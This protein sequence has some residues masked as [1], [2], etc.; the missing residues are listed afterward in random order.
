MDGSRV[1]WRAALA[2]TFRQAGGRSVLASRRHEGPL[3]VQKPLYPEG[4]DVCHAVLI[5]APGGIAG[6]DTL[7]LALSVEDGAHAL[8]TTPAAGKWYKAAGATAYQTGNITIQGRAV[9]EWLPQE[10]ILFDHARASI[11]TDVALEAASVFAGWE[12]VCLGRRASGEDF[13]NGALRQ[14]LRLSR[15]GR[16]IWGEHLNLRGGDVVMHSPAGLGGHHVYGS[17]VVAA[18]SVPRGMVD[19]CRQTAPRSGTCGV[20]VQIGPFMRMPAPDNPAV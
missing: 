2:L 5:H 3:M 8:V 4:G 15:D 18:G 11:E 19:A 1:P 7:A 9:L 17:M 14:Q 13:A 16:A 20:G 6:G 12:V 10:T